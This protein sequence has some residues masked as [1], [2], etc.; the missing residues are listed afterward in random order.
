MGVE[1]AVR[2][3]DLFHNVGDARAVVPAAPNGARSRPDDPFVGD[4]LAAWG[5]PPGG[6]S[7][8][9]MI[10]IYQSDAERKGRQGA[11][12]TE[13]YAIALADVQGSRVCEFRCDS[14]TIPGRSSGSDSQHR[15]PEHRVVATLCRDSPDKSTPWGSGG[16][17]LS[18]G[19]FGASA[20]L[21]GLSPAPA[22]DA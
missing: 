17:G 5:G 13:R 2:Q 20:P 12:R 14:A 16:R 3:A 4:F 22:A 19:A 10:I 18:V 9:M 6:G 1:A 15:C 8:H 7:V 21:A 11:K